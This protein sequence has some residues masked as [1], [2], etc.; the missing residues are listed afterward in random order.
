M[1]HMHMP[2]SDAMEEDDPYAEELSATQQTQDPSQ[3]ISSQAER[4]S[5]AHLWGYL[6]PCR[7]SLHRVDFW[8][9][10]RE[11]SFGR[12]NENDVQLP[13]LKIS[14][15]PSHHYKLSDY[16]TIIS[17]RQQTLLYHLGWARG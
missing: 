14:E 4:D 7:D 1:I 6:I 9:M 8:K 13:S 15:H 17:A 11:I 3:P 5:N 16:I 10:S 2:M 12:S